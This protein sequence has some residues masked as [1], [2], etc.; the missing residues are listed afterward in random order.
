MANSYI[1][2]EYDDNGLRFSQNYTNG[3]EILHLYVDLKRNH[4]I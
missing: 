1:N 3:K 2:I 4:R